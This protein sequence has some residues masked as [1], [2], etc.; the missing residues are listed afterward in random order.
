[1]TSRISS[2]SDSVAAASASR[3]VSISRRN[4]ASSSSTFAGVAVTTVCSDTTWSCN[5]RR[6]VSVC[7]SSD[8]VASSSRA[9]RRASSKRIS[10]TSATRVDSAARSRLVLGSRAQRGD[11]FGLTADRQ[12]LRL[13]L[14]RPSCA[15]D[16]PRASS[17]P[18][19][20]ACASV[21]RRADC[22]CASATA[23]SAVRWASTSVR[24]RTSSDSLRLAAPTTRLAAASAR[25]RLHE[26]DRAVG[27]PPPRRRTAL[28]G[29]RR[30]RPGRTR[31]SIRWNVVS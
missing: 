21:T 26:A 1:M 10:S 7:C 12:L 31:G 22:S 13:R 23:A 15:N 16:R 4:C 24:R 2:W 8:A 28:V 3:R 17:M 6:C 18:V 19:A 14:R 11:R 29:T 27:P 30:P 20:F 25:D 5:A 9:R